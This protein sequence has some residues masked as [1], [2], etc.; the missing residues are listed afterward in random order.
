MPRKRGAPFRPADHGALAEFDDRVGELVMSRSHTFDTIA[1]EL[2]CGRSTCWKAWRRYLAKAS[3]P[4]EAKVAEYRADA[5]A[6]FQSVILTVHEKAMSGDLKAALVMSRMEAS[7][8]LV[9]GYAAAQKHVHSGPDG[10][11]IEIRDVTDELRSK[12]D[13]LA[14]AIRTRGVDSEPQPN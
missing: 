13:R 1:R 5:D 14:E 7:H 8:A 4:D 2:N 10:K 11:P 12:F 3:K 6:R 9:M